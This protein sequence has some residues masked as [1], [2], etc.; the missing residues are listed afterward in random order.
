M[1]APLL[2]RGKTEKLCSRVL[3]WTS[4]GQTYFPILN[5]LSFL[6]LFI[7]WC[8]VSALGWEFIKEYSFLPEEED[9][10]V[11]LDQ[12]RGAGS[13][14]KTTLI[15]AAPVLPLPHPPPTADSCALRAREERVWY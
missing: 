6:P 15:Y 2:P 14:V 1:A 13:E 11:L 5:E 8:P 4:R 3:F 10:P 7:L 9:D 12:L